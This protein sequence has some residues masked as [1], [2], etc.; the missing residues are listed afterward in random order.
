MTSHSP[1]NLSRWNFYQLLK[2]Y[3]IKIGGHFRTNSSA[4]NDREENSTPVNQ[5]EIETSQ[6]NVKN[7][8]TIGKQLSNASIALACKN[9]TDSGNQSMSSNIIYKNE[10]NDA[11]SLA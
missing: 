10:L 6:A 8:L 5:R 3:D 9:V 11:I 4:S 1:S 2:D 7:D